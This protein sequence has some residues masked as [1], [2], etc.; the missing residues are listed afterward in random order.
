M[1]IIVI[2]ENVGPA[3]PETLDA[4]LSSWIWNCAICAVEPFDS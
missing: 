4:T 3:A 2:V 1:A